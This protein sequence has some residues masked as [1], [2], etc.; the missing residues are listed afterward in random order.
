LKLLQIKSKESLRLFREPIDRKAWGSSPP[1]VVNAFYTASRNQISKGNVNDDCI[2]CLSLLK[3]FPAGILQM[4]FFN[5][6]AP[7]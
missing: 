4:P 2:L 1:T 5:K 7:K 6:D 3:G